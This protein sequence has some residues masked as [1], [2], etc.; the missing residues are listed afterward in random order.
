M[1]YEGK[2]IEQFGSF[3]PLFKKYIEGDDLGKIFSFLK[4]ETGKGK[5]IFPDS[6]NVFRSFA[7]CSRESMKVLIL[8][9]DPYNT[10]TK[11]G[12]VVSDGIP[13]S[14]ALTG[15][16]Q[17]SLQN[18]YE[19]MEDQCIGFDVEMD[20]RADNSYLLR[21]EGVMIL[22]SSLTVE[23]LKPGSHE[24]IWS[25]FM[26]YFLEEIVN[27]YYKGLP[28]VLLGSQAQKLEKWINPMLHYILK[29][30]HMAAAAHQNR[31]WNSMNMFLWVNRILEANNGQ[32]VRWYRTRAERDTTDIPEWVTSKMPLDKKELKSGKELGLPFD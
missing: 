7:E 3:S 29:V 20:Y 2:I 1:K 12:K 19:E 10:T 5:R 30:E 16:L 27:V 8:S 23:M 22:N 4:S 6:K 21:E 14:C 15:K 26:R 13:M 32:Q 24:T 9:Q 11:E 28:I 17:P 18:F 25:N 31:R